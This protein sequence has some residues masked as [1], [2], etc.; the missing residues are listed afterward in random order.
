[1]AGLVVSA[2]DFVGRLTVANTAVGGYNTKMVLAKLQEM[3]PPPECGRIRILVVFYGANDARLEDNEGGVQQHVPLEQYRENL[4]RII[5]DPRV[6][7]HN[8]KIIVM[9]PPPIDEYMWEKSCE[10]W[11]SFRVRK[12]KVTEAVR[13]SCTGRDEGDRGR[14]GGLVVHLHGPGR[15]E[16]RRSSSRIQRG[17]AEP[18]GW[19]ASPAMRRAALDR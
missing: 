9:T 4:I 14:A 3:I 5:T 18:S 12:A 13:R 7:A 17:R 11:N 15:L 10:E 19:L 2:D 1:M 8:P 16:A 6:K